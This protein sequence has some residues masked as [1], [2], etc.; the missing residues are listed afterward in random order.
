[1]WLID[2]IMLNKSTDI[3]VKNLMRYKGKL[4]NIPKIENLLKNVIDDKFTNQKMYKLI[5][6]LKNRG[7]IYNIKKNIFLVKNPENEINQ[8]KV[9]N[10]FYRQILKKHCNEFLK[11]DRYI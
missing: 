4:I 7:Y 9:L 8:S 11:S 1:M 3:V 10:D 2:C 5:Y 6:Y